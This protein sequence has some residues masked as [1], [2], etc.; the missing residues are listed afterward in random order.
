MKCPECGEEIPAQTKVCPN[1]DYELTDAEYAAANPAA[2]AKSE[3]VKPQAPVKLS[4]SSDSSERHPTHSAPASVAPESVMAHGNVDVSSHHS[5]DNSTHNIDNSQTVHNTTQNV[6]NNTQNTQ[7][8]TN[9]FI[10]MGGAAPLPSNIDPQTAEALKQAQ[11]AQSQAPSAP[12]SQP[13]AQPQQSNQAHKNTANGGSATKGIGSIDGSIAYDNQPKSALGKWIGIGVAVVAVIVLLVFL[14]KPSSKQTTTPVAQTE[15]I[16]TTPKPTANN[17]QP[18][19]NTQKQTSAPKAATTTSTPKASSTTTT[20]KPATT[21]ASAPK[22]LAQMSAAEAYQAGMKLYN[23][24][25]YVDCLEYLQKAANGGNGDAAF[26]LGSM[27]E[28]G[29]GVDA[30]ADTALSWYKKAANAGNKAAKRKLF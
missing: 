2:P 29:T 4:D 14:F 24:G 6:Q 26:Q 15:Q 22:T 23:Q 3:K 21:T 27:Y 13:A 10:I 25:K 28:T 11:A 30:N 1:C 7:N 8:V 9:T 12:A 19:A 20:S 5:E 16:V 17:Q 18:A